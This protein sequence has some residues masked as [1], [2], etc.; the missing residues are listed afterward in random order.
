M[1][2]KL[3]KHTFSGAFALVCGVCIA[4]IVSSCK[5]NEDETTVSAECYISSVKL[6]Y[7]SRITTVTGTDGKPQ[8]VRSTY[9]GGGYTMSIDQTQNPSIISNERS[10]LL[11]GTIR[12]KVL[13]TIVATGTVLYRPTNQLAEAWT[14]YSSSDS[15]DISSDIIFR[16]QATNGTNYRD[17]KM[18]ISVRS[19]DPA[20]FTWD[21]LHSVAPFDRY[22]RIKAVWGDEGVTAIAADATTVDV[23]TSKDD[24]LKTWQRTQ[25][26]ADN[27]VLRDADVETLTQWNNRLWMSTKDGRTLS[28]NGGTWSDVT[29]HTGL[30]IITGLDSL[31]ALSA[32]RR[33]WAMGADEMWKETLCDEPDELPTSGA[34]G[35]A[36]D[37]TLGDR[38]VM[39]A[40]RSA[41][42]ATTSTVWGR[43]LSTKAGQWVHYCITAENRYALPALEDMNMAYYN[44]QIVAT[45]KDLKA[46][47][48]SV[49]NG[50]TWKPDY[51]WCLP[52][53]AKRLT[54]ASTLLTDNA[55]HLW[56][57]RGKTIY[58][59][60]ANTLK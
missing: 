25:S 5:K 33:M 8:E 12:G 47:Y 42:A 45:G 29:T 3:R 16:V 22:T 46:A 38:R 23:W 52:P 49:D 28:C 37:M 19:N 58:R 10:P 36:Y 34:V 51:G 53:W 17:Y 60:R 43:T 24:S 41:D 11:Y 1:H 55:N 54:G 56:L 13:M 44:K 57:L 27:N 59:G 4:L 6:G 31:Y 20:S 7:M 32:D 18:T 21:S 26:S 39:M 2:I 50:V 30:R 15:I 35:V 9:D 14:A 40:G 48:I